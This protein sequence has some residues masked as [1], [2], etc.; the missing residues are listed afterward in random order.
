[1]QGYTCTSPGL[2]RHF[3]NSK[4]AG[5]TSCNANVAATKF[6]AQEEPSVD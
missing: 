4:H 2:L 5:S 6:D 1:M 3:V